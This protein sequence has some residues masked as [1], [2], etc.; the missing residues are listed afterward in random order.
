MLFTP[1]FPPGCGV[2]RRGLVDVVD[3]KSCCAEADE[4]ENGEEAENS[5]GEDIYTAKRLRVVAKVSEESARLRYNI[6]LW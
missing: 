5:V 2:G 3:D 6:R 4:S 1:V